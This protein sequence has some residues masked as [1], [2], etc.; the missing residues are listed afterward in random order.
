[1]KSLSDVGQRA[2]GLSGINSSNLAYSIHHANE[3]IVA[4]IFREI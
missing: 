2:L 1:M 4:A 3:V